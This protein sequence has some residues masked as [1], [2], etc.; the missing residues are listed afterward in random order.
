VNGRLVGGAPTRGNLSWYFDPLPTNC[1]ADWVCPAG[2]GVGFPQWACRDGPEYGYKN[3]AVFNPE[4]PY[5]LL[6]FHPQ[7]YLHDLP[8][9]SRD[10]AE[11]AL[12]AAKAAGL[13][14]VRIG[15]RHLLGSD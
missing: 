11:E 12:A 8:V 13:A 10:H 15:N 2:T 5:S 9:T 14:R 1:V 7:F 4:I 3:L 6:A